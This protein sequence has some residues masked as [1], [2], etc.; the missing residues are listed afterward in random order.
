MK[1]TNT[2]EKLAK[3]A[4]M[5]GI[6]ALLSLC[7]G[8]AIKMLIASPIAGS[9]AL[10]MTLELFVIFAMI[11]IVAVAYLW[12]CDDKREPNRHFMACILVI[13][14]APMAY[15]AIQAQSLF[16]LL[17][18]IAGLTSCVWGIHRSRKAKPTAESR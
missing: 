10:A 12:L 11:S 6:L 7:A 8:A 3:N 15:A 16:S 17:A 13:L 14:A 1:S 4:S 5:L 2:L 18:Y 9:M